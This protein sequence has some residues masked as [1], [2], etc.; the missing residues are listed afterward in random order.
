M[1]SPVFGTTESATGG[2][3]AETDSELRQRIKNHVHDLG[4]GTQRAIL[5]T[6]IGVNDPDEGKR[7]V[8]AFLREPTETGQLGILFIDDGTGF[9]PSFAGVGEEVM[10]TSAAGTE[11]FFQL[12]QFPLV[13]AQAVSVGIEPFNLVGGEKLLVEVDGESEERT[14]SNSGYRTPGVVTAQE[15]AEEI[16]LVF[17]N[18]EARAKNGHLF[19]G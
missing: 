7:V 18:I 4:R 1:F 11:Q 16:N 12:Q 6:V 17:T 8:S 19:R 15:V 9:S 5:S 13:K 2:I 10:V 3:D 14:L